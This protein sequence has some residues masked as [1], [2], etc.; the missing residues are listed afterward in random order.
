MLRSLNFSKLPDTILLSIS[1]VLS[2]GTVSSIES[3][4]DSIEID[5]VNNLDID[6]TI[7]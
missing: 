2:S 7:L 5:L 4:S 1:S 6:S 3:V